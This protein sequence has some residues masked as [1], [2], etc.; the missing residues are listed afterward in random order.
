MLRRAT[1]ADLPAIETFLAPRGATSMF[2][3]G[4]L[5]D[6]GL[7]ADQV[8]DHPKSMTLWFSECAGVVANVFGFA[9]AGYFVFEAPSFDPDMAFDLRQVLSGRIL[10][11]LN[12]A[13]EQ[14]DVVVTALALQ[15]EA[16]VLDE[17]EPHYRLSLADL[18][19][20]VGRSA[21]RPAHSGDLDLLTDWRMAS[22]V[23]IL[24]GS[25]NPENRAYA[26]ASLQELLAADRLRLLEEEGRPV[27]MTNFN[28][29]LPEIVQVGGVYTPPDLRGLGH[30]RRAVALHLDEARKSGVKEAI[31]FAANPAAARAYEAIG[32]VQIGGYRIVNFDPGITLGE[33][34]LGELS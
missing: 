9:K 31:L 6:Y 13:A 1:Q 32:F 11:G 16:A 27:A 17:V 4:N 25:D 15:T 29:A 18:E 34:Q 7:G 30:A 33:T 5:R 8:Q 23:E 2:L 22:E 20:P 26:R 24:G 12:G 19:V 28:A 3:S 21:L 10:R 14:V